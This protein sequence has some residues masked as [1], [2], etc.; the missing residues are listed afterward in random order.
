MLKK[1]AAL[2]MLAAAFALAPSAPA[3]AE[4]GY[5]AKIPTV[6]HIQVITAEPGK[7]IVLEVSASADY[8]TPPAGD[9]AVTVS[10]SGTAARGARA[11]VSKPVFTTT[12][13]F[14]D[15]PIRVT[16]PRLPK[17]AYLARQDFSPDNTAL[18]LPSSDSTRFRIG[19]ADGGEPGGALPNT[20][21]P[22]MAWLL[23][24]G[25]LVAVGAGGVGFGRRRGTAAA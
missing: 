8:P 10:S 22:D 7:P 9:I 17:G 20:G 16:G 15:R 12:V 23:L 3:G 25:G 18:F 11:L 1:L 6:S 14:T 19:A 4:D 24:G 21:G 5:T 13:H 2:G